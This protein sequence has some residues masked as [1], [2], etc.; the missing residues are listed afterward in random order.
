M[1]LH[2]GLKPVI[3]RLSGTAHPRKQRSP[4]G[5][6]VVAQAAGADTKTIEKT[7]YK[8]MLLHKYFLC[9]GAHSSVHSNMFRATPTSSRVA[10]WQGNDAKGIKVD[11]SSIEKDINR[12]AEVIVGKSDTSKLSAEEA[13]RA[14]AWSVRDALL[15]A[16][17]KTQEHWT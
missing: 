17:F 2:G 10:W 13:Y 7:A 8:V 4:T 11:Q 6:R 9:T 1:M 14:V 16:F 15:D 3:N 5:C 12:K